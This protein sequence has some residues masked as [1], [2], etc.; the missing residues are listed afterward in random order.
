MKDRINERVLA[1]NGEAV[2][3]SGPYLLHYQ[4]E[5]SNI[6]KELTE[7]ERGECERLVKE[8]NANGPDPETKAL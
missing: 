4:E 2:P 6:A 8:W 3:G 7:E 1:T 5:C